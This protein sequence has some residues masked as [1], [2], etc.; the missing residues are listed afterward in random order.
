MRYADR[1]LAPVTVIALMLG[2]IGAD[3]C[4]ADVPVA[5]LRRRARLAVLVVGALGALALVPDDTKV[6]GLTGTSAIARPA[7]LV[8]PL[9]LVA[10]LLRHERG[11]LPWPSV[12]AAAVVALAASVSAPAALYWLANGAVYSDFDATHAQM[13][14]AIRAVTEP[15]ARVAVSSAG[16]IVYFAHRDGIDILG[17]MDPAI[18]HEGIH[19][20]WFF[21]PGHMKWDYRL[22]LEQHP[23]LVVAP[24]VPTAADADALEAA[25]YRLAELDPHDTDPV[26]RQAATS[27]IPILVPAPARGVDVTRLQLRA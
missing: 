16:A 20:G 27:G 13:G 5:A 18:A 6:F 11:S 7:T 23:E 19:P 24:W 14:A 2:A 10:A 21:W 17:K 9:L 1:Y 12:R 8:G 4:S 25:G 3:V 26:V 15:N 22:T